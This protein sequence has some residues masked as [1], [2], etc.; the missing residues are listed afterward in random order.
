VQADINHF[1]CKTITMP[2]YDDHDQ[3]DD[4]DYDIRIRRDGRRDVFGPNPHS[5]IGITSVWLALAVFFGYLLTVGLIC[6][7]EEQN[8]PLQEDDP[9]GIVLGLGI[10]GSGCLNLAGVVL[11]FAGCFQSNRNPIWAIVGATLNVILFIGIIGLVCAG[12]VG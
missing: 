7:I 5:G 9:L 8:G 6:A 4:D 10:I 12:L 3:Y 1:S 2:H 11:G